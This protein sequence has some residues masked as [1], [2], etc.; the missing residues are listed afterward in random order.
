MPRTNNRRHND[1][2]LA[3]STHMGAVQLLVSNRRLMEDYYVRGVGLT[4]LSSK[5]GRTELGLDGK[6]ILTL[7]DAPGLRRP[8][9]KA[10]GLFHTAILFP[11]AKA[12]A[13]SLSR[14][15]IRHPET[16]VGPGDHAVSQAF[17]FTD[18]EGNGLELYTDR[19][20][21]SWIWDSGQVFMDTRYIDHNAFL[22]ENLGVSGTQRALDDARDLAKIP[23]IKA[24]NADDGLRVSGQVG[25]VH[26]QVGD[27][28]TARQF[29]VDA[30][31]FEQTASI[32]N[33]ALFVST[34]KYHHHMAMNVWNSRGAGP[35]TKTLGLGKVGVVV[36]NAEELNNTRERLT[37]HGYAVNSDGAA[38]LVN[39]PWKNQIR[40]T[41][42]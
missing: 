12:L 29:Y 18:P 36:P 1:D 28:Q 10:A 11:E 4:P 30:L 40:I 16:Y 31:G 22:M 42:A 37:S 34:G 33:Q 9:S 15:L 14:M 35:R 38:L 20:R 17:Y 21:E 41:T 32:G 24:I 3:G 13:K 6:L 2:L 27:V 23:T 7:V 39:D 5:P 19:P 26:L 8:H 25:H